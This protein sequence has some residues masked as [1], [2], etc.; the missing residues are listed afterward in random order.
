LRDYYTNV[1]K[2]AIDCKYSVQDTLP[3][4]Y[5]IT[6]DPRD[7][8]F[9]EFKKK[10]KKFDRGLILNEK[11]PPKHIQQNFWLLKPANMN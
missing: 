4:A 9:G 6:S 11:M 1:C 2:E 3:M 7:L 8:E 5:I 10:M